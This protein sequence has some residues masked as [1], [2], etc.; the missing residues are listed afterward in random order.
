MQ[1]VNSEILKLKALINNKQN[2]SVF[3]N[4]AND[5]NQ[6]VHD[7]YKLY[8]NDMTK[9]FTFTTANT[10][11][12]ITVDTRTHTLGGVEYID[13]LKISDIKTFKQQLDAEVEARIAG[14]EALDEAKA[15][16][17]H[18]HEISDVSGL[19]TALDNKSNTN[20]T[21]STFTDITVNTINGCSI[22]DLTNSGNNLVPVPCIPTIRTDGCMEVGKYIDMHTTYNTA[23]DYA[24]RLEADSG[25]LVIRS[26]SATGTYINPL[27]IISST[28]TTTMRLHR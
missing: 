15:D 9:K 13:D 19:Q 1:D 24:V 10:L 26:T 6:L 28:T 5:C 16:K 23:N 3:A 2:T 25:N 27:Q 21:H 8:V 7:G 14:D 17:E 18:T 11:N 4:K 22:N 20:H 12:P